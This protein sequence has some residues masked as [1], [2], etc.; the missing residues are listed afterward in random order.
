ML[1]RLS[2]II[3]CSAFFSVSCT[4]SHNLG[5]EK[6]PI[7]LFLIPG[8]DARVLEDNGKKVAQFLHEKTG[9]AF[10][11]KVPTSYIAVVEAF[12]SKK[13]DVA[14]MNTFGYILAYEKYGVQAKLMGVHYGQRYYQGQIITR[15]GHL[16]KIEDIDGK[17]FAFVDPA[18]TSGFLMPAELLR[19]KNIKPKEFVFAGKHD[20]VI[21]ML[22]QKQVDAGAT[23]YTPEKDG[24]PQDARKLVLTQFPDVF[25]KIEILKLTDPIPND[26]IVFR[27]EMEE[28]LK[29]KIKKALIDFLE[30]EYGKDT[31]MKLYNMNGVISVD[32]THY[33]EI[34][35]TLKSLGKSAQEFIKK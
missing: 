26:P 34:R 18:S 17:R 29:I 28:D 1:Y 7:K 24:K 13:A 2:L 6:N 23:F 22:Y 9:L 8:Q 27:G 32:D 14:I 33:D 3:F 11:V 25:D 31:F 20:T 30:T 12:G 35:N 21:S 16:K 15:K 5:T 19:K 4:S 10:D